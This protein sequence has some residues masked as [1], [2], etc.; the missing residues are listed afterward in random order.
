MY[1][2]VSQ[3]NQQRCQSRTPR[4]AKKS[5]FARQDVE[6]MR[7]RRR[8]LS[9]HGVLR[10]LAA[11]GIQPK[12]K[13]GASNDRYE[14]E[15]DRV[16]AQVMRMPEPR[17]QR[18]CAC[19]GA[20]AK[21][22]ARHRSE[23]ERVQPQRFHARAAGPSAAPPAVDRALRTPGRSLDAATRAFFEPRFGADFSRVRVH[24]DGQAAE[25]ARSV[26]A[27]AFTV[28]RDVVFGAGQYAP[29]ALEGR[30][31]LA[32]ELTH[33]MQQQSAGAGRVL[34]RDQLPCPSR[35]CAG[36]AAPTGWKDYYGASSVFH[37]GFRGILEDRAPTEGSPQN[38]CFYDERCRLVTRSHAYSAC[39]GTPNEY[40][41]EEDTFLH[42]VWDSGGVVWAGLPAF[43]ESRTHDFH[44]L[45][46]PVTREIARWEEALKSGWVPRF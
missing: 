26:Q 29:G 45:I 7:P 44:E 30:R 16:A 28:G 15:A 46:S 23:D 39:G 5:R 13:V 17:L 33:V 31:L 19:G 43:V 21:C 25:A 11:E 42:T 20:C 40:D 18:A 6:P 12:L 8:T 22:Q 2:Q 32:H 41:S 37:C 35:L 34:Q 4:T 9:N 24:T 14:Q 38:E 1:Q 10:Q 36:T 27:R 3:K